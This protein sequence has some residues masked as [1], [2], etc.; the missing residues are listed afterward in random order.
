MVSKRVV[1][2]H[3]PAICGD[4]VHLDVKIGADRGACD[5]V[6]FA[7]EVGG[8]VEVGGDSIRRQ[9]RVIGIADWVVAPKRGRC[10]E[11]LVHAAKQIDIG[12]VGCAA[13]PTTRCRK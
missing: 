10:R 2:S 9:V 6:D 5:A 3:R 11:V 8:G 4:G 12:A 7:V 1:C 13:E